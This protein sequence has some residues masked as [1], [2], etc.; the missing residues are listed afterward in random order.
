MNDML[1]N[2]NNILSMFHHM[3]FDFVIVLKL[4]CTFPNYCFEEHLF[5]VTEKVNGFR[6]TC[7]LFQN[8]GA[9]SGIIVA[10]FR[11]LGTF[12]VN[13]FP[14]TEH[15]SLFRKTCSL[16]PNFWAFSGTC[17]RASS[18]KF[19]GFKFSIVQNKV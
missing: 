6:N 2:K 12:Q 17:S 16:F 3:M 13:L 7:S 14:I 15:W 10:C 19:P 4:G 8:I 11:T 18:P 9:F 5:P 1:R